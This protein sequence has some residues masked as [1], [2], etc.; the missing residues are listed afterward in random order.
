MTLLILALLLA[1]PAAA[2][3]QRLYPTLDWPLLIGVPTVFSAVAFIAYRSDK[4][5]AQDGGWRVPELT[6]HLLDLLGGWP[7]AFL[8]QRRYRHKTA[9]ASFQLIFWVTVLAYELVAL[10]A[11]LGWRFSRE[12]WRAVAS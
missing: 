6:L 12:V 2:A 9:K 4:Q 5:R 1:L 3:S 10:D 7:G 8:A 11:L